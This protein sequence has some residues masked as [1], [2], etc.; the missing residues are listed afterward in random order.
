MSEKYNLEMM[1]ERIYCNKVILRL[2][3]VISDIN[4]LA[5]YRL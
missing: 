1:M 3:S 2:M 4:F 5:K